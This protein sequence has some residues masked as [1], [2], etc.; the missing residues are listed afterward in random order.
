MKATR[1]AK[2]ARDVARLEVT[3]DGTGMTGRAGTALLGRV[4]DRVGLTD[5]LSQAIGRCRSWTEHDPGKVV[6]DLVL[7]LADGGDALRHLK[8]LEGQ[9]ELFGEVASAAPP[10]ARSSRWPT[11]S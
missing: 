2:K 11:T 7:M 6:R 5:G 9:V 1:N 10:T 4:A 8:V 3:A